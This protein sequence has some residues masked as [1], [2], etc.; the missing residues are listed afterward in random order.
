MFL[1]LNTAVGGTGG[2]T[3]NNGTLPQTSW[4]DYARITP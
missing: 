1:I 2:G 3:V 4:F